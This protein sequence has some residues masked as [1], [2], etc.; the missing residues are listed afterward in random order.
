MP[1]LFPV[2]VIGILFTYYFINP[3][4]ES[5]PIHCM[6]KELTDTECPSCGTQRAL[7]SLVHGE[8]MTALKYNCFF[9]ISIPYAF[10]AVLCTWY[11]Y[12]NI[13]DGIKSIIYDART[14]KLYVLLYFLWWIIRNILKI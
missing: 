13:F 6:W 14:L 10:L 5:F 3:I 9:L 12:K 4:Q 11:N 8:I 2:L 1:Y 7:H